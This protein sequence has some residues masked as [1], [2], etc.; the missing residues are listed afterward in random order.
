IPETTNKVNIKQLDDFIKK[1]N[2]AYLKP[3]NGSRGKGIRYIEKKEDQY[4]VLENYEDDKKY[5]SSDEMSVFLSK[6][7]YYMLQQ[8]ILLHAYENRKVDYRVLLQKNENGHWQCTGIIAR[9]GKTNAISSNFKANGFAKEGAEALKIQFGYD[10]LKAF[11]KYQEIILICIKMA[12]KVDEIGA[13]A[14]LGIDI[15][16]DEDEKV[17]VIEMNKRPDHDFPLMIKDR[18]MYYLVKSNPIL[19]A[20][21]VAMGGK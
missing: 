16:I 21:Y 10:E 3:I 2:G 19:Y 7:S 4:L 6:F 17:W 13:Y 18:K 11:Q 1:Y 20:K 8:P 14:D 9:F 5:M 15:G 12:N